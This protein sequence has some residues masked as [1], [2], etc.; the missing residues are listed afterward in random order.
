M[1]INKGVA[2]SMG[3]LASVSLGITQES[4]TSQYLIKFTIQD[5]TQER[6]VR[7]IQNKKGGL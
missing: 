6:R 5:I 1:R 4:D 2:L 7:E 3:L